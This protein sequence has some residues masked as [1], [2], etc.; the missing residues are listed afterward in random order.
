MCI[1]KFVDQ[2]FVINMGYFRHDFISPT[3]C[4]RVFDLITHCKGFI[5]NC[6]EVAKMYLKE[7]S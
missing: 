5:E 7:D 4:E 6:F 1:G 2:I 3:R